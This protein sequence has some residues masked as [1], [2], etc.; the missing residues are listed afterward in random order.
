VAG[1]DIVDAGVYH[2]WAKDTEIAEYLSDAWLSYLGADHTA[3][4]R[5]TP[6]PA[7]VPRSRYPN[8]LGEMRPEALGADGAYPA[9]DLATLRE[10][11]LDRHGIS[12]AILCHHLGLGLPGI[13]N[14]RLSNELIAAANNYMLDR[15]VAADPRLHAAIIVPTQVPEAGVAEIK[16]LASHPGVAAVMLSVNGLAKPFGHE[17][18]H[19]IYRAACEAGLPVMLHA[20]ADTPVDV[21]SHPTAGGLPAT[22]SEL[23]VHS[24]LPMNTHLMSLIGQGA[25]DRFPEL[26]I[27]AV[28]AG[29][30]WLVSSLL[31]AENGYKEGRRTVPWTHQSPMEYFRTRILIGTQP[32]DR[33]EPPGKIGDYL[34][35]IEGMQDMLCFASGYPS[36]DSDQPADITERLPAAWHDSVMSSNANQVF[37]WSGSG[38]SGVAAGSGVGGDREFV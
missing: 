14:T 2:N 24:G 10:K 3:P 23:Y 26:R 31:R 9:S 25:F 20:G 21:D 4:N 32:L 22:F 28:G 34:S 35:T 18:Y 15:W 17:A 30:G 36:W 11:H 38:S 19:P 6:G 27:V 37:R 13:P 7:I 12:K 8:P 33:T 16:R 29:V 1:A 5:K